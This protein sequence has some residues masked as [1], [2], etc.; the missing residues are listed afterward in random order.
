MI[1]LTYGNSFNQ[2][3]N[4]KRTDNFSNTSNTYNDIVPTLSNNFKNNYHTHTV[5]VGF[6]YATTKSQIIVSANMQRSYLA[7]VQT[8]PRDT[9]FSRNFNNLLP[10]IQ[11]RY[12]INSKKNLRVNYRTN[13]N[14]PD[15]S[16]LQNVLN[17]SN[18]LQLSIGN[19]SLKQT[20]EQNMF[21]RYSYTNPAK[22]S[23]FFALLRETLLKTISPAVHKLQQQILY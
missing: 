13:T 21:I 17:N 19:P 4:D 9:T 1:Q 3:N 18:T 11:W 7:S 15:V 22:S 8:F 5:G 16:Q 14:Q 23:S 6:R 2:T 10:S 12:N 20:F